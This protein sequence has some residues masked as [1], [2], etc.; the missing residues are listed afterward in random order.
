MDEQ[1][2]NDGSPKTSV[3]KRLAYGGRPSN[4]G[5]PLRRTSQSQ[6]F[7]NRY[8]LTLPE[9][10]LSTLAMHDDRTSMTLEALLRPLSGSDPSGRSLQYDPIYDHVKEARRAD[11]PTAP[12]DIWS[13]DLKVADWHA[14]QRLCE[15]ALTSE[16]KDLQ[17]C[18]WLT[19]AWLHLEG[20]QGLRRGVNL[21]LKM[22]ESYWETVHPTLSEGVDFRVA[23]FV[24]VNEKLP[25]ALGQVQIV[26]PHD[27]PILA[28]TW[29]DWKK[30]LWL[31][32]VSA[33]HPQDPELLQEL[34][35]R[36][37]IGE[38]RSRSSKTP[39][40][41]FQDNLAALD[42][43]IGVTR[44]LEAFLDDRLERE[45]P[46]LVRFRAVLEEIRTWTQVVV[47]EGSFRP[48]A[49]GG[50]EMPE[51]EGGPEMTDEEN[52]GGPDAAASVATSQEPRA[53]GPITGRAD[54]Y[55]MLREAARYLK[56]VEPHSPT[57]YL[58]L[59]A[60]SWGDKTLDDLLREFV[61]EGLNL[62]ALFTF[63]GIEP[64][65]ER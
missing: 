64:D 11:D 7:S 50:P 51:K 3:V 44:A 17:I 55:R 58:V 56:E 52:P 5:H 18:A 8:N 47:R 20:L 57:P 49:E 19:E 43:T 39:E 38:F 63:L 59:K 54:A 10:N 37:T 13:K 16:T 33:R 60:V 30:A 28:A 23:P 40:A 36:P 53:A 41:F 9:R 46:S 62:E 26:A 34:E 45:S 4:N 14:V 6:E 27:E 32:K 12:R 42:D 15:E 48:E 61:R 21:L 24:W 35:A 25:D 22:S 29:N 2:T 1:G 65:D 31:D